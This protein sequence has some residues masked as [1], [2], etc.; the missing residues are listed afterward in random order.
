MVTRKK[1][2]VLLV[3]DTLTLARS[4]IQFLRDEPYEVEHVDLGK[5]ALEAYHAKRPDVM[6]LDLMLPDMDGMEVL[7]QIRESDPTLPVIM[8]TAHGSVQTAVNAMQGGA[9]DFLVKPFNAERLKMTLKNTLEKSELTEIVKTYRQTMDA[10]GYEGFVGSSLG[11][12]AVYRIIDAAAP[13]SATV[14]ITGE[15]GTGKEVCAEAIRARSPRADGPMI[16]LNCAAIPHELIESEIFGHVKGAFSGAV[17]NREGAAQL[18]DGGTLFL[19]EICEMDPDLQAKL[20]RF[21]QTKTFRKVGGTKIE[22]VDVRLICATNKDPLAEVRAGRFREDLYYR[23]HVIPLQLPPLRERAED[24]TEIA[25]YFLAIYS[26]QEGR[27][28]QGFSQESEDTLMSYTWP[29]N[30]RELQNVV[31]NVVVLNDGEVVLPEMLPPP[32]STPGS[33]VAGMQVGDAAPTPTAPAPDVAHVS[34]SPAEPAAAATP[35]ASN[36]NASAA[37]QPDT[38]ADG[39]PDFIMAPRRVQRANVGELSSHIKPL[40]SVERTYIEWAIELC[41]GNIRT[42]ATLLGIAP[43]TIYRKRTAWEAMDR[44]A[45]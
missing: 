25:K 10:D 45:G 24:I 41:G 4:Y 6:L 3:E 15:S 11:M 18:A 32:L 44:E 35:M 27:R 33:Q 28:F 22:K 2:H 43:Q 38:Y 42:A 17:T 39:T 29:G 19:D 20:L 30:V 23:L 21:L 13:S 12:Q 36:A 34:P 14:F 16:A 1:T 40:S 8:I 37:P 31:Q 26:E 7:R 5:K 9:G